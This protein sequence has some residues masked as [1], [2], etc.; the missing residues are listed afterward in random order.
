MAHLPPHLGSNTAI[1]SPSVARIAAS[2]ARDWNYVDS[3]LSAKFHGRTPPAFER[4]PETLKAL[5]AL[6]AVNEAADEERELLSRAEA[7]AL[8]ELKSHHVPNNSTHGKDDDGKDLVDSLLGLLEDGL[9]R[10]GKAALDVLAKLSSQ[11]GVVYPQPE[12]LGQRL[13]DLQG[14]L[15]S[16]Q[17][18][19]QRVEVMQRYLDNET[20][21]TAALLETVQGEDCKPPGDLA[22]RNLEMQR[23]IKTA[24][25]KLGLDGPLASPRPAQ[26]YEQRQQ[27]HPTVEQV[28]RLED[29]YLTFMA[30]KK[31]VAS[32]VACFQ[33]L[34]PDINMARAE[35]EELRSDLRHLTRKKDAIFEGLVERETPRKRPQP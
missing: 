35:L 32:Q 28:A 34:P 9:T 4:N 7:T 21:K 11:A 31:E 26:F 22:K 6:A 5:I 23:K 29:N 12:A 15:F 19:C 16:L 14:R 27:R 30:R 1:F 13:V 20:D 3:W 17:Q 2:T 10:E 24:A 25:S 33:G 18:A 8:Q